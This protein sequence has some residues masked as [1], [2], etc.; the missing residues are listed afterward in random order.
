[1]AD[2][3][4]PELLAG[5]LAGLC[6]CGVIRISSVGVNRSPMVSHGANAVPLF[7]VLLIRPL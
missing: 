5:V 7:S 4:Q 1:M 3:M 6:H 2:M